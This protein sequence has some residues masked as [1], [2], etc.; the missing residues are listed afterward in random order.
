MRSDDSGR[1]C[2]AT[3]TTPNRSIDEGKP[4][5]LPAPVRCPARI[6]GPLVINNRST[7]GRAS[8]PL[9]FPRRLLGRGR[10]SGSVLVSA[11]YPFRTLAG[12]LLSTRT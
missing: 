4:H 12:R 7:T 3:Q 11:F 5:C 1:C 8:A 2:T 6:V 9:K 10:S